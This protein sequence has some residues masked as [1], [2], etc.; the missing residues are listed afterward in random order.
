MLEAFAS[1]RKVL[2]P[3][4]AGRKL[5][6]TSSAACNIK[7]SMASEN[8]D[9]ES[10]ARWAAAPWK[11]G[12]LA[13]LLLGFDAFVGDVDSC[14]RRRQEV[15]CSA[16]LPCGR[17]GVRREMCFSADTV[18]HPSFCACSKMLYISLLAHC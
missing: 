1:P 11:I 2:A 9:Y 17:H 4:E 16:H 5:L 18:R 3:D 14:F 13:G 12:V 8:G 7:A 6:C 15:A 10:A